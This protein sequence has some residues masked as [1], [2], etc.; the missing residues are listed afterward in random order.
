MHCLFR[1]ED[2]LIVCSATKISNTDLLRQCTSLILS[3]TYCDICTLKQGSVK[4]IALLSTTKSDIKLAFYRLPNGFLDTL[5][6]QEAE[7][8]IESIVE[9]H[10]LAISNKDSST[11]VLQDKDI[12]KIYFDMLNVVNAKFMKIHTGA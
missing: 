3:K 11:S 2:Y 12:F 4:K 8:I 6:Y 10:K 1:Y 7:L 9:Q 5:P